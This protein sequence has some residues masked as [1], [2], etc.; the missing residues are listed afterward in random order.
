MVTELTRLHKT[1]STKILF[2][3]HELEKL[4]VDPSNYSRALR[5]QHMLGYL[6]I[7]SSEYKQSA[8]R[9]CKYGILVRLNHMRKAMVTELTGLPMT[10]TTTGS[11]KNNKL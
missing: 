10:P 11:S 3:L 2:T 4:C 1:P 7:Y 9:K 5:S 8:K 6:V